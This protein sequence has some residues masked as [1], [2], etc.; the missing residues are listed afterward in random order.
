MEQNFAELFNQAA[1]DDTP[2]SCSPD[3]EE[4]IT[5][6]DEVDGQYFMI[7]QMEGL[8][9]GG[10]DSAQLSRADEWSSMEL[11]ARGEAESAD[12]INNNQDPFE[13]V[14][15]QDE[16]LLLTPGGDLMSEVVQLLDFKQISTPFGINYGDSA[17]FENDVGRECTSEKEELTAPGDQT[18]NENQEPLGDARNDIQEP[19]DK[20]TEAMTCY[21]GFEA[22]ERG[23]CSQSEESDMDSDGGRDTLGPDIKNLL[24]MQK[25]NTD[26]ELGK[27]SG[28]DQEG[29]EKKILNANNGNDI[30]KIPTVLDKPEL[31]NEKGCA[32]ATG[33]ECMESRLPFSYTSEI[34]VHAS[35]TR[36][37][38][39]KLALTNELQ[40]PAAQIL[41]EDM[42]ED[43]QEYCKMELVTE[44]PFCK[45]EE[46]TMI[47]SNLEI[48][49]FVF[50]R[51]FIVNAGFGQGD[52]LDLHPEQESSQDFTASIMSVGTEIH[53]EFPR[54]VSSH[55]L[56]EQVIEPI[57]YEGREHN[58]MKHGELF[59][60]EEEAYMEYDQ[61][62]DEEIQ[63]VC[64][65]GLSN[66]KTEE[67]AMCHGSIVVKTA[68]E[69]KMFYSEMCFN[70]DRDEEQQGSSETED[71]VNME[72]DKQLWST[73]L[74]QQEL[75]FLRASSSHQLEEDSLEED[76]NN[77]VNK[78]GS[79]DRYLQA[80]SPTKCSDDQDSKEDS[81]EERRRHDITDKLDPEVLHLLEM[82]LL[83]QQLVVIKE[84]QEEEPGFDDIH[85]NEQREN[86]EA[87]VGSRK[88]TPPLDIVLEEPELAE[89]N[90]QTVGSSKEVG[91]KDMTLLEQDLYKGSR[92]SEPE[93]RKMGW[94]GPVQLSFRTG[95]TDIARKDLGKVIQESLCQGESIEQHLGIYTEEIKA[96]IEQ[97]ENKDKDREI[98]EDITGDLDYQMRSGYKQH[99]M[100]VAPGVTGITSKYCLEE[101]SYKTTQMKEGLGNFMNTNFPLK[102]EKPV[103][104]EEE[105]SGSSFPIHSIRKL[106]SGGFGELKV[107]FECQQRI[108]AGENTKKVSLDSKEDT[109]SESIGFDEKIKKYF[110]STTTS[111]TE[112]DSRN[113]KNWT[114]EPNE[115]TEF[116]GSDTEPTN[117]FKVCI[118]ESPYP[119][120]RDHN[121]PQE[122]QGPKDLTT[123]SASR[124]SL[125]GD[126]QKT[127]LEISAAAAPVAIYKPL[128]EGHAAERGGLETPPENTAL[129]CVTAADISLP[130]GNGFGSQEVDLQ[131]QLS[132]AV[133]KARARERRA[134]ELQAEVQ[135]LQQEIRDL[136]QENTELL[137]LSEH[138]TCQPERGAHWVGEPQT[139]MPIKA[140]GVPE[141]V[142]LRETEE[143]GQ[144]TGSKGA[145]QLARLRREFDF[146]RQ[147]S[148]SLVEQLNSLQQQ[149]RTLRQVNRKPSSMCMA[150]WGKPGGSTGDLVVLVG[151]GPAGLNS[152]PPTSTFV[153]VTGS[154]WMLW[155]LP[156]TSFFFF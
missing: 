106:E 117:I 49:S 83:K 101:S 116:L 121:Y 104:L 97:S 91:F 54:A 73:D 103:S 68:P 22:D 64:S 74:V 131:D 84:E 156:A 2:L 152:V 36:D 85:I 70:Q 29:H 6:R 28:S 46:E 39:A 38:I 151:D 123:Q 137:L 78:E 53:C 89:E 144:N 128:K 48:K 55:D 45:G 20:D 86:F 149:L 150:F 57:I 130:L 134:S 51:D 115:G 65:T 107:A 75:R 154:A 143:E 34:D 41:E 127:V 145:E 92:F 47:F 138:K 72:A 27:S 114:I 37:L 119:A 18:E 125:E 13:G 5:S 140:Q 77:K 105:L 7:N 3:E 96:C 129:K 155:T 93:Y 10:Q 146:V 60:K 30:D 98:L 59:P 148:R 66:L 126:N 87:F 50:E 69:P 111:S 135:H 95:S 26:T 79:R 19:E 108:C 17:M 118:L 23:L 24:E 9:G 120:E 56:E 100:V 112:T 82:H 147:E 94:D 81:D 58:Q 21:A 132:D 71:D 136:R 109:N 52:H 62:L 8:S 25:M 142:A 110:G 33:E 1:S 141:S 31:L 90:E 11:D 61:T 42:N 133:E 124:G 40:V 12:R 113:W 67:T 80:D 63:E 4:A 16:G 99:I 32:I 15:F 102:E 139:E 153:P 88:F 35:D 122:G 76:Y 43:L 14:D 44:E